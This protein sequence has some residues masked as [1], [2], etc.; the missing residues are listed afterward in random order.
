MGFILFTLLLAIPSFQFFSSYSKIFLCF[1]WLS[2]V[3]RF[4][5]TQERSRFFEVFFSFNSIMLGFPFI[6]F[7]QFFIRFIG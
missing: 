1:F 6:G 2:N 4:G 3:G 7:N 5:S